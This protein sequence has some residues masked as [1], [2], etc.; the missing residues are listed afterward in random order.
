[1]G[2]KG[3]T[4]YIAN[5]AEQYLKPFELHDCAL[6]IDGDSL[7]SNLYQWS[8]DCNSAFGGDYDVYHRIV[9]DFFDQLRRCNVRSFV[10]LDG[11]YQSRKL[12]TVQQRLR[13]KI[14]AIKHINPI[15]GHHLF[16]LMMREVF[17]EAV[18]SCAGVQ[19]MRCLFEADDEVAMLARQL[20]CPV[21]SYDSDF[22]IHNVQYI[23]S[24][25][26][27]IKVLKRSAPRRN[28][29]KPSATSKAALAAFRPYNYMDCCV[30][31]I[32]N[33]AGKQIRD[34]V[35]PLFGTLLGND[36]INRVVFKKF[37]DNIS[38][39]NI[40]KRNSPQQK[41]IIALLRWM[42]GETLES[43]L[44]KVMDRVEKTK[45][46]WLAREI[47]EAMVGYVRADSKAF[48][49]F[50]LTE[51]DV[52]D[53]DVEENICEVDDSDED[54]SSE[55]D[56]QSDDIGSDEEIDGHSENESVEP[57]DRTYRDGVASADFDTPTWLLPRML[58]AELPR[59]TIDL[60]SLRMYINS[61]QVENF[62]LPDSNELA[63]PI[64]QLIFTLLH[65]PKPP[66]DQFQYL[67]RIQ[68][69]SNVHFRSIAPIDIT[70]ILFDPTNAATNL[71]IFRS[72]FANH[73]GVIE[74]AQT[75]DEQHQL[76]FLCIVYAAQHSKHLSVAHFHSLVISLFVLNDATRLCPPLTK[77]AAD[78]EKKY[79]KRLSEITALSTNTK[80][81]KA[82]QAMLLYRNVLPHFALN[83]RIRS[84]H[85]EFSST[86]V[87]AFAEL[88]AVM[89]Q[90]GTLNTL[91]G[92]PFAGMSPAHLS[93]GSLW[94][95]LADALKSR[96]DIA[97]YVRLYVFANCDTFFEL[98]SN[99]LVALQ[100]FIRCLAAP[101][102][103]TRKMTRNRRKKEKKAAGKTV[104]VAD[105]DDGS[106]VRKVGDGS[107]SD[108]SFDDVNNMF[109]ALRVGV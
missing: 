22:Y 10:L 28:R 37:F 69:A 60:L 24:V 106:A 91:L 49:Y 100:P 108:G 52:M 87:H 48:A 56:D 20:N 95:N 55:I 31:T 8:S 92:K 47:D 6:V 32:A 64:L 97:H 103:V 82:D 9:T 41:R 34:E 88:Q 70:S 57:G 40:G 1:M 21:L 109:A 102:E 29:R 13:D 63:L 25:S 2:V 101:M 104:V 59:Y 76:F 72:L 75:L 33:L 39:R 62:Q 30:Y 83:P 43:A 58:A 12:R 38:T 51:D 45:R 81:P 74:A 61:P 46:A 50:G 96:A 5:K 67:T 98:Y 23:P 27:T 17:V 36:Y 105:N 80:P 66:P 4:T 73:P 79:S 65:H 7:A 71:D 18:R 93:N 94:Y 68:R 35:L 77:K 15:A 89:F 53:R 84:R 107:E 16:P 85:T 42:R 90:M 54:D 11:G 86:T 19:V 44:S 99:F 3:L 26:L 78:F 14:A